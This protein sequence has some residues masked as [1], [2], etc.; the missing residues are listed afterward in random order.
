MQRSSILTRTRLSC[1]RPSGSLCLSVCLRLSVSVPVCRG[2][3][4]ASGRY[5]QLNRTPGRK[6]CVELVPKAG[7]TFALPSDDTRTHTHTKTITN[8]VAPSRVQS[9][10]RVRWP[11][12]ESTRTQAELLQIGLVMQKPLRGGIVRPSHTHGLFRL[13]LR[14]LL[15]A[16]QRQCLRRHCLLITHT[17]RDTPRFFY[18]DGRTSLAY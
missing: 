16:D 15:L 9:F 2:K 11:E 13:L 3:S 5:A 12:E 7:R 17:H 14:L 18:I 8:Y 10:A 1:A 6:W 4:S